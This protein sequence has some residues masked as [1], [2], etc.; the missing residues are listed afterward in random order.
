MRKLTTLS[1][2][3]LVTGLLFVTSCKEQEK[4]IE[5]TTPDAVE[6]DN[7]NTAQ[8]S[9]PVDVQMDLVPVSVQTSFK[10]KYA[11][12]DK[13]SW[14]KYYVTT[15]EDDIRLIPNNDYYYVIY[16]NDGADYTTW[17]DTTGV[18]IKSSM[19]ISGPKELPDAVNMTLNKEYPD[20]TITEIDKENDK[21]IEVY[22]IDLEKGESKVK[23]KVSPDGTVVKRKEK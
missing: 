17:Y 16:N 21:N 19:R 14:K 13:I 11:N 7:S 23:V 15:E 8:R 1:L 9:G 18:M 12:A 2:S 10:S 22:E 4:T 20:Y 5:T 6:I 3:L